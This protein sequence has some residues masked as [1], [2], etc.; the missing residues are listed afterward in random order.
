MLHLLRDLAE[1]GNWSAASVYFATRLAS[2]IAASMKLRLD[3]VMKVH[4]LK[5]RVDSSLGRSLIVRSLPR[6]IHSCPGMRVELHEANSSEHPL[7][8]DIDVA[9]CVGPIAAADLV[10]RQ[11]AV[12]P[13]VTC[14]APDF[15]EAESALQTPMGLAPENCIAV[16]EPRTHRAREWRFRRGAATHVISPAALLA[17]SDV[18]SAVL[19]AVSGA[20]YVRVLCTEVA[21]E[22]AAGVLRQVFEDWNDERVPVLLVWAREREPRVE[23]DLFA[24]FVA[25]LFPTNARGQ[26]GWARNSG[27]HRD[28]Q[29]VAASGSTSNPLW[30]LSSRPALH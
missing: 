2:T 28:R 21:R 13:L 30:V 12:L 25:G 11:I 23:L 29:L 10:A 3:S 8:R 9:V 19:A 16:L 14:V 1:I 7:G 18:E 15:I 26:G 24:T 5:I 20:G 17:F 6:F 27:R 22:I 4:A